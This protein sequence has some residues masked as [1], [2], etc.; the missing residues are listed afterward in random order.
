MRKPVTAL[1]ALVLA[2][3]CGPQSDARA[4]GQLA[5]VATIGMITDIAQNVGGSRVRVQGLMGPG[6][7][8][9]LYKARAGDVRKIASADIVFY[10]GL[11]LEAAMSEVLEELDAWLP[12]IAV[13]ERIPREQLLRPQE[14]RGNYDP[15]VWFDVRLWMQAVE[16]VRDALA[17]MDPAGAQEYHAN[18]AAYL[19][20]LSR[21]DAWVR[22]RIAEL[23]ADR[24]VLVTAHDAFNYFGRAY[25]FEVRGLQGIST[26]AEAGTS[27]VQLLAREI[28]SRRIPAVFIETS[29]AQRTIE[30]V[31]AAARARGFDVAIGGALF[32]DAMGTAGT[33]EGTYIGMVEHNVNTIVNGLRGAALR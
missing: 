1:L 21:L 7:D 30:A 13:T 33:R 20:K 16:R 22:S 15:H 28:A 5:V 9:H 17:A 31:Q 18:A 27:D 4:D 23:P 14:F 2:I 29:I 32:S 3:A 24:R 6:V 26:A 12:A 8:P 11:H 19:A 25:G 10:N